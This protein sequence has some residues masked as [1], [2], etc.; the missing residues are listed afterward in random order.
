MATYVLIPGMCHG[1][2]C[3][4]EL[5]G[6]LRAEGHRVHPLT[7]TG[8]AERGHLLHGGV[9]LDTHIRDGVGVLDAE[10]IEDAVLVGHSYGG[11]VITGM[12]DRAPDRVGT[13]VFL[14]A[15][16]PGNGDSCWSLVTD[17]ERRWYTDVTDTGYGVRP[18]PFFDTR[19]TPHPL[20]SL[21]QPLRL[22]G[23]LAH[24]RRRVY[25][26][27]AGWAGPSPFTPVY[28]RLREDP[29]WTTY[30]LDGGHNLMRDAPQ[31]L[32]KVLLEAA[33]PG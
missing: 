31:D 12:A 18:L 9:N 21:M 10:N 22:T 20:A 27:A 14:D 24:L 3:F 13:L 28:R 5:T 8:L 1:G 7:L 15:M 33:E 6:R 2:W 16:V 25:V 4:E 29:A 23:D 32:L 30:A 17:E 26:Y 19:A 11:M